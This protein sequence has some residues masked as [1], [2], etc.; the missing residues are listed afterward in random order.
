MGPRAMKR[1]A[2]SS[3]R[4]HRRCASVRRRSRRRGARRTSRRC[5]PIP[6]FYHQRP[7]VVVGEVSSSRQRRAASSRTTPDRSASCS[8]ATR[9]DGLDEIRGEFW[10]LGR[11][12]PDD[13]RL[14]G[15]RPQGER[16]SID[17]E[18]AWPRPGQVTAIVATAV[19]PASPPPAPSIRTI[20][21]ESVAL[22]RTEGHGHR[23]VRRTQ[24]A[25]R[26]A[27]RAGQSRYD[28]VL[29]SADA[30]IWVTNLRPKGKDFELA[31]DARIDTGRWLEVTGTLQQGRGLQWLDAEAAATRARA[32]PRPTRHR[33]RAGDSRAG[34]A[35]ARSGVQRADAGRNR[36]RGHDAACA[37]SSR[38]TSIRRRSR[39]T[40]VCS[41]STH[42]PPIARR[43]T[44]PVAQFTTQ[45][46]PARTACSS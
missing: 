21:L 6:T 2:E 33:K 24:P 35:A 13:P 37:S 32:R 27:G 12:K 15:L 30:A 44:T 38:A 46:L 18:G 26:S 5:S 39:A 42:R 17:P 40:S 16:F 29:R 3:R 1:L 31:L 41:I 8:K 7:I 14:A 43:P 34:G 22:P 9:P 45:Y 11:M 10:D 36:R 28:F 20:V 23:T 4:C 25:R 19:T